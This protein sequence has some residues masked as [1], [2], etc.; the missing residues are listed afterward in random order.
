M[1]IIRSVARQPIVPD[2]EQSLF[3][4]GILDSFALTDFV[5]ALE[6]EFALQIPDSDLD[7]RKFESVARIDD[8]LNT[9]L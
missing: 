1:E 4:S 7:P 8:Y 3:E 5:A 9:R 2:P 6:S